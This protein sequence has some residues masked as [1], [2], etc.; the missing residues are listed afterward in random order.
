MFLGSHGDGHNAFAVFDHRA[1]LVVRTEGCLE[2]LGRK[3]GAPTRLRQG[4]WG[5]HLLSLASHAFAVDRD[6][7]P[8]EEL[9]RLEAFVDSKAR[10]AK[11]QSMP[12]QSQP[13][14]DPPDEPK[15]RLKYWT[16]VLQA[17][18]IRFEDPSFFALRDRTGLYASG[19]L[20]RERDA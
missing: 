7:P 9:G 12:E 16:K 4:T 18:K 17:I 1:F 14:H 8:D 19:V 6:A 2:T 3:R 15:V 13:H 10:E 11:A 5:Q 20:A